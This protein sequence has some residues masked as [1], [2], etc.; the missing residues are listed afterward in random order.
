MNFNNAQTDMNAAYFGGGPG[1]LI[2]GL[3]WCAAG[4]VALLVSTQASMLTLFFGGMAIHPLGMLLAKLLK[5]TG[6]HASDNPLGKLAIEST[7]IIFVGLFLA[8]YVAKLQV[9]WFYP[10]MLMAIGVRYLVFNTLYGNKLY[11]L[12]GGA[13]IVSGMLC[14]VLN[15]AFATGAF[16]GGVVEVVFAF[17]I[18]MRSKRMKAEVA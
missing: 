3:V 5:R 12:L 16:V 8:F 13:L 7:V 10:I 18:L 11:W 6:Q 15:A 2:S 17:V 4:I 9:E 1:V 14:V